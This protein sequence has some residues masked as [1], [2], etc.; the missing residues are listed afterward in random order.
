MVLK[1]RVATQIVQTMQHRLVCFRAQSFAINGDQ[2]RYVAILCFDE[3]LHRVAALVNLAD[4]IA[5]RLMVRFLGQ[6]V[7]RRTSAVGSSAT[8]LA[9]WAL[10]PG[11]EEW[12][13]RKSRT[14][15][16][17]GPSPELTC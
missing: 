7:S 4:L 1:F 15:R 2:A 17:I 11:A 16:A 8:P 6:R 3:L 12:E 5:E 9:A 14:K 10:A 13:Q